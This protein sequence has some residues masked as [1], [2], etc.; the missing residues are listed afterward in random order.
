MKKGIDILRF[1]RYVDG[2]CD[3]LISF[4]KVV[5]ITE[6]KGQGPRPEGWTQE[7]WEG[8]F[9]RRINAECSAVQNAASE[10][11]S[12]VEGKTVEQLLAHAPAPPRA[13]DNPANIPVPPANP[14]AAAR[15]AEKQQRE[16]K[17]KSEPKRKK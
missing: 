16:P 10:D 1:K 9:L 3:A 17:R 8:E 5:T 15:E 2:S 12:D 6:H 7:Q 11:T 14:K 13:E 4:D